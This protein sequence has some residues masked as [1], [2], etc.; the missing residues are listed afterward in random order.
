VEGEGFDPPLF[1]GLE[2][3]LGRW[4]ADQRAAAAAG[5]R[6]RA[7]WLGHQAAESATVAGVLLDLAERWAVVRIETAGGSHEGRVEAVTSGLCALRR[8]DRGITLIALPAVTA[9]HTGA[10]TATGDRSPELHLDMAGALAALSAERTEVSVELLGGT[11]VRG[12]V[13]AVGLELV[14]LRVGLEP[15]AEIVV[16][17]VDAVTACLL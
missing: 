16:V 2:D 5:A 10:R 7:R 4:A 3:A 1:E 13:Q 8:A 6:R 15:A 9:V 17:V 11:R 12:G 14:S